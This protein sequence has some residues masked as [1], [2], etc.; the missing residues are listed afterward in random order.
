MFRKFRRPFLSSVTSEDGQAHEWNHCRHAAHHC[1]GHFE[2]STKAWLA[3]T[4]YL[5]IKRF[6]LFALRFLSVLCSNELALSHARW[7][8]VTAHTAFRT[9]IC[10]LS[11]QN[12]GI[13]STWRRLIVGGKR[14]RTIFVIVV[15][16]P[17][18]A[19]FLIA[20]VI[21]AFGAGMFSAERST[22]SFRKSSHYTEIADTSTGLRT[23]VSPTAFNLTHLAGRLI[24]VAMIT[25]I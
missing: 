15:I 22:A 6:F 7:R 10:I 3:L 19:V 20:V 16:C 1:H 2:S 4:T 11:L 25:R 23:S 12:C 21:S 24:I 17:E 5:T 8:W 14:T 18:I 13:R 9:L